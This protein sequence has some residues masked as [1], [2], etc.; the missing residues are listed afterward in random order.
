MNIPNKPLLSVYQWVS[1]KSINF[2]ESFVR[3]ELDDQLYFINSG[4]NRGPDCFT[5]EYLGTSDTQGVS[6]RKMQSAHVF[7]TFI[8]P[9]NFALASAKS[10]SYVLQQYYSESSL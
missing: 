8:W 6:E 4:F 9:Y 10:D 7:S 3:T 1:P 2:N 5:A